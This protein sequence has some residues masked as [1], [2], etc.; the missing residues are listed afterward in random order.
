[1]NLTRRSLLVY[2]LLVAVWGLVI[3]W[4]IEE[5][6]HVR[7]VAKTELRNSSRS[8]ANTLSAI[9][10]SLRFRGRGTVSQEN[11]Q[12]ALNELVSGTNE[13]VKSSEIASIVLLNAANEP[14]V[15][16]GKP[17]ETKDMLQ[18]GEQ[19]WSRE[20]VMLVNPVDLGAIVTS[21]GVTDPAV[22]LASPTNSSN[23]MRPRPRREP[24]TEENSSSNNAA[25][26]SP[27]LAPA[28]N[29]T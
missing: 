27:N 14:V 2:G 15:T 5:H 19:R 23:G 16:A 7:E 29:A 13:L 4:Q 1:M 10:R 28:S 11:L 17:V 9:I 26:L 25:G 24:R 12:G 20:N 18:S 3:V 22:V 8:I 6:L 21:E